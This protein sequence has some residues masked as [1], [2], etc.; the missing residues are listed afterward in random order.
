M[1]YVLKTAA[2]EILPA[3]NLAG[4]CK[5]LEL[6]ANWVV[7]DRID[8][9]PLGADAL[10]KIA[11]ALSKQGTGDRDIK[12]LEEEVNEALSFGNLR[13][14]LVAFCRHFDLPDSTFIAW[15]AWQ[16]FAL[17]L[18][19]EV[20]GREISI[21]D[22]VKNARAAM[23]NVPMLEEHRPTAL[24]LAVDREMRK[25]WWLIKLPVAE[26]Q[27]QVLFGGFRMSDFPTPVGWRS[28]LPHS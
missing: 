3:N 4:K 26:V 12:W 16:L 14:D 13:L 18:A 11:E 10:V 17:A 19:F 23:A 20:S 15:E 25:C 5:H 2:R 21:S 1:V 6:F 9:S 27:M 7:H 8:R 24:R 22:R 28:P